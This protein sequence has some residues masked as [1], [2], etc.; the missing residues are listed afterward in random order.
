[1]SKVTGFLGVGIKTLLDKTRFW[2][3]PKSTNCK[4]PFFFIPIPWST[5]QEKVANVGAVERQLLAGVV[6]V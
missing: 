6:P 2:F 5:S 4:P 1:M 3:E